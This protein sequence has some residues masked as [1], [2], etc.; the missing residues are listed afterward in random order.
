[1]QR[2]WFTY[3][4]LTGTRTDGDVGS[5]RRRIH[6]VADGCR[7][8]VWI[9]GVHSEDVVAFTHRDGTVARHVGFET[10]PRANVHLQRHSVAR[11]TCTQNTFLHDVPLIIRDALDSIFWYPA[12]TG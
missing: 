10:R 3:R 8:F 2:R 4:V 12:G 9:A 5:R 7:R 11:Q 1:M 6:K